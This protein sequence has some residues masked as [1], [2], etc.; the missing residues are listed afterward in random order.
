MR[1]PDLSSN[2]QGSRH[3]EPIQLL[4]NR[5]DTNSE[6]RP[7]LQSIGGYPTLS[8]HPR[9]RPQARTRPSILQRPRSMAA[10]CVLNRPRNLTSPTFSNSRAQPPASLCRRGQSEQPAVG[11]RLMSSPPHGGV[12][13]SRDDPRDDAGAHSLVALANG[14]ARL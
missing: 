4:A 2:R 13:A 8:A 9:Y 12:S 3:H 11:A 7:H 5:G 14:E 6:I 10:P 1:R